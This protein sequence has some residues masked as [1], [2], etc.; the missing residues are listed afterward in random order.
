MEPKCCLRA[1]IA[2]VDLFMKLARSQ[3]EEALDPR[4]SK[5]FYYY[6]KID[7]LL[8]NVYDQVR[9]KIDLVQYTPS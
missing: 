1:S 3:L 4:K 8:L 2:A 5:T 6:Y 9:D 7:G